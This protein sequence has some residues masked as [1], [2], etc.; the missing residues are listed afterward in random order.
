VFDFEELEWHYQV[1][2]R[3]E[4]LPVKEEPEEDDEDGEN[5]GNGSLLEPKKEKDGDM[6]SLDDI[7]DESPKL[8]DLEPAMSEVAGTSSVENTQAAPPSE[9]IDNP[10]LRA[11]KKMKYESS[12][13]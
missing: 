2:N 11:P 8:G 1:A 6:K 4:D 9:K 10:Y 7:K 13:K 3:K 12:Y 5:E